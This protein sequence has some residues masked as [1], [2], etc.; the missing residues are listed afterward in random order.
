[1]HGYE[2]YEKSTKKKAVLAYFENYVRSIEKHGYMNP[3][4]FPVDMFPL[5]CL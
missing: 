5:P 3:P 1:M 2:I 4:A